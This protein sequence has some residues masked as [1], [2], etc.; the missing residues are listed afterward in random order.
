MMM[1]NKLLEK[2][3]DNVKVEKAVLE[4]QILGTGT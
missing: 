3:K 1:L 4:I 2:D